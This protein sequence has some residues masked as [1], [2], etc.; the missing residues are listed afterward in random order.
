MVAKGVN[1]LLAGRRDDS[2]AQT[3][4]SLEIDP[5]CSPAYEVI[6]EAHMIKKMYPQ[7]AAAFQKYL[8]LNNRD[9]DALMRLANCYA[10]MGRTDEAKKLLHELENPPPSIYVSPDAI[11][12]VYAGLGQNQKAIEELHRAVRSRASGLI[13]LKRDPIF[14]PLWNDPQYQAILRQMGFSS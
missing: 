3:R 10:V 7:A 4:K 5:N 14:A 6:G 8:E 13:Q 2:L 9:P 11:A 12:A 1:L